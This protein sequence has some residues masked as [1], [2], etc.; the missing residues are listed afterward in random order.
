M[1]APTNTA[2]TSAISLGTLPASVSQD[3]H[4]SGTTYEVWY[5]LTAPAGATVIG[6]FGFG[7]LSVYRP[8]TLVYTGPAASPVA[9][10]GLGA[11]NKPF[12]FPVT[13]GTEYF[14][15]VTPNGGN[16]SPAILLIE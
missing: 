2:A 9:Y 14:F 10:L 15:K 5:T 16:P 8:T 11:Q 1:P 13:P 7:D 6:F 4:F 3:V 12:Q